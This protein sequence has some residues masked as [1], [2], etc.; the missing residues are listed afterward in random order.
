MFRMM[1]RWRAA[2]ATALLVVAANP[3]IVVA[4]QP[5]QRVPYLDPSLPLDRRAGIARRAR[6]I[7]DAAKWHTEQYGVPAAAVRK[8]TLRN[9]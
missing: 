1:P 8:F 4:Q 2:A 7:A 3:F 5:L 6:K 9:A